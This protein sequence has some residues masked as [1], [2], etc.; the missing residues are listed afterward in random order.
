MKS[1]LLQLLVTLFSLAILTGLTFSLVYAGGFFQAGEPVVVPASSYPGH[2]TEVNGVLFFS[3]DDGEHGAELWMTDGT[4]AG[5]QLVADIYPGPESSFPT[6]LTNVNGTLYFS[7]DDGLHGTELWISNGTEAGTKLF[8]DINPGVIELFVTDAISPT[9][10]V[11]TT[12]ATTPDIL[13]PTPTITPTTVNLNRANYVLAMG[14][15]HLY[16]E[17]WGGDRGDPCEAWR[18]GNFDDNDP[19][20]R[21]FN[22]ELKLT[23]NTDEKVA[24]DW[25]EQLSFVTSGG[26]ELKACYYGY[27]GMGPPPKGTTSVTF[28][29][30]VPKGDYVSLAEVQIDDETLRLCFDGRGGAFQCR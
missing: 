18:S 4:P 21:G 24:D 30:V 8:A 28:F 17:P 9:N 2:L 19:N 22:L 14:N 20:Y 7:A 1:R 27:D 12:D 29:S 11:T 16:E 3:A 15:Q 13:A 26:K 10:A 25:A 5:T 6:D 23:N